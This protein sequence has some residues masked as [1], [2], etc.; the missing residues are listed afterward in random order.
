MFITPLN[1]TNKNCNFKNWNRE[2][3]AKS[4]NLKSKQLLYRNDTSFFRDR[5]YWPKLLNYLIEKFKNIPKVNVYNFGCSDG[6]EP[7]SFIMYFLSNKSKEIQDKFLPVKAFDIDNDA[8]NRIK[9]KFPYRVTDIEMN[10]INEYTN[11]NFNNF[12]KHIPNTENYIAND[13]LYSKI[14]AKIGD[15]K[16]EYKNIEPNN[17]IIFARNF[18]PYIEGMERRQIVLNKLSERLNNNSYLVIGEYD[19]RGTGWRMDEQLDKA[20]FQKTLIRNLYTKF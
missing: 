4:L 2:V 18:W 8:I 7:L 13:I 6:S 12:F 15:I 10:R 16:K 1:N 14:D 11:G 5:D 20:G 17:S 3:Y 19:I 9:T